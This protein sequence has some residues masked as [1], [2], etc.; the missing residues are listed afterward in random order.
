[1]NPEAGFRNWKKAMEKFKEHEESYTH[2][3]ASAKVEQQS[4]ISVRYMSDKGLKLFLDEKHYVT[5]HDVLL[6]E[7]QMHVLNF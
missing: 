1:M 4:I 2:K 5:V 3:I 7:E 6:E